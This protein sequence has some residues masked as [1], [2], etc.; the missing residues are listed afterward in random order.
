MV[1]EQED[2]KLLAPELGNRFGALG[3]GGDFISLQLQ[4]CMDK[5][6]KRVF[7]IDIETFP[8]GQRL[9]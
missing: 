1:I 2:V 4:V 8:V 3:C 6:Q 7:I 9:P 5:I